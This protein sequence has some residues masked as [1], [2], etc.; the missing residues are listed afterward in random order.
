[1]TT[2]DP[3][4]STPQQSRNEIAGDLREI[5]AADSVLADDESVRP[6]ECDGLS[7]YRQLPL[8]VVLPETIEEVQA[9]IRYCFEKEIPIVARGAG[10]GLSGGAV[11]IGDGI[12]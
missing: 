3:S 4:L 5:V 10:T 2:A 12:V 1:M 6:Y 9:T 7:A 11:P 8:A